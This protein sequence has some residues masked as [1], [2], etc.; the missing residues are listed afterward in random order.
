MK[1]GYTGYVRT[2]MQLA[3]VD[4]ESMER[5]QYETWTPYLSGRSEDRLQGT[6]GVEPRD[7]EDGS[8]AVP[9]R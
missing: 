7:G 5:S 2:T 8:L 3:G 6:E 4:L 9:E 1:Y